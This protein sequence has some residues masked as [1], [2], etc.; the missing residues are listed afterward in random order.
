MA[1]YTA[2]LRELIQNGFDIGLD[3]YPIF[4][5]SY[6]E[7]LNNKIINHYGFREIGVDVPAR[8]KH[9]INT[10]MNEIMPYYNQIYITQNK[11]LAKELD[12]NV[13][14]KETLQRSQKSDALSNSASNSTGSNKNKAVFQDTPSGELIQ[15]KI[16]ELDYATNFSINDSNLENSI[17]DESTSKVEN[18]EDYVKM[19]TGNNGNKYSIESLGM[20]RSHLMN[21]DLEIIKNL[22]DLFMGL[23]A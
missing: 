11:I 23:W 21:I 9:E 20:L 22:N 15:A 8:F 14:L 13:N 3:E 17:E 7:V 5:E 10:R 16:D 18:S 1:T 4:D 12:E 19:I 6:R 2:Q